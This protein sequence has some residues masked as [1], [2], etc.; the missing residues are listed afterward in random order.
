M[1][2]AGAGSSPVSSF[3][4]SELSTWNSGA[5]TGV[6]QYQGVGS[7]D[8]LTNVVHRRALSPRSYAGRGSRWC[9]RRDRLRAPRRAPQQVDYSGGDVRDLGRGT[10]CRPALGASS[11]TALGEYLSNG[12]LLGDAACH[13]GLA[14]DL[15][16]CCAGAAEAEAGVMVSHR[17]C[18][19]MAPHRRRAPDRRASQTHILGRMKR[20]PLVL[21]IAIALGREILL[22]TSPLRPGRWLFVIVTALCLAISACYEFIEWWSA[23]L[24]GQGAEAFLGTQGDVWDTQWDM[25]M[26]LIGAIVAQLLLSNVHNR[27][28]RQLMNQQQPGSQ[29]SE[30]HA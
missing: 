10:F 25:L 8:D 28:V 6:L 21:L 1:G 2:C 20:L 13:A 15:R 5:R 18:G 12:S 11:L 4:C 24:F 26:A 19:F 7:P 27:A 23:L 16:R 30:A 14:G 17:S 9:R 22:R 3:N 29:P